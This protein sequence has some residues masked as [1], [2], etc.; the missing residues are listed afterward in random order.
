M[1]TKCPVCDSENIEIKK[2]FRPL[3]VPLAEPVQQEISVCHCNDCVSDIL[4]DSESKKVVQSRIL[5]RAKESVPTLLKKVNECGYSD[6]RLERALGLA[7]HTINRWKQGTQVSAAA[8]ALSRFV[9][10]LPELTLVAEAGFDE[11][12]ARAAI[13]KKTVDKIK[14]V[15][16]SVRSFYLNTDVFKAAGIVAFNNAASNEKAELSS[17]A[18]PA[19]MEV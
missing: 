14:A 17:F 8:I 12:Y 5:E 7:P 10:I 15:D 19:L 2:D 6:S 18:Q 16:S 9:S 3:I 1:I 13:L 4:L 11:S